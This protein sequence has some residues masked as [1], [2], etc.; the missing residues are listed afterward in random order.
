MKLSKIYSNKPNTF[1]PI[2]FVS[3]LNVILAEIRLPQNREKD[4][5][6]L[7]KTTLGGMIDFCLL[8][9]RNKKFFLFKHLDLFCEFIFFL[10]IELMDGSFVTVRR[11][12]DQASRIS[13]KTH[14]VGRQDFTKLSG[15]DWDHLDIS[16]DRAKTLLDGLLDFHTL[17]PWNYRKGLGYLIRS[18]DDFRDVFQLRKFASAHGDWKPFL[19]KILGFDEKLVSAHY[20]KEKEIDKKENTALTINAEMGSSVKDISKIEGFLLLK[21]RESEKKQTLLDSFDFREQDKEKTKSL[22]DDIDVRI[23]TLNSVRYSLN[24]NK[25]R[26]VSSLKEEKILFNPEEAQKLF[27]EAGIIFDGQIK[28]D[29]QQLIDFNKAITEERSAYLMEERVE[30]E[31]ELRHIN[32]ELNKLGKRRSESLSFLSDTDVFN[33]YKQISDELVT[34]KA[35]IVSLEH[36]RALSHRLQELRTEIRSL[37]EEKGKLQA[38]IENDVEKQNSEST[39]IFSSIRLFFSEIIE[40]VIDRKALLSVSPN[41]HGHLEFKAEILDESGN[42]TSADL[43]NT[44]RKLLCAAFDLSVLRVYLDQ[45]FPR[46][47]YHDGIFESLDHRKKENLLGII[48]KYTEYGIQNIITLIDSDLPATSEPQTSVF[49]ESE[50][51]LLLHDE[52]K[53]GRLFKMDSF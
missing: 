35:D 4:T 10:E 53:Q 21:K 50:I 32:A 28:K 8:S 22:V 45:D 14:R 11:S 29:Y 40:E 13:V 12:V 41:Q 26:V 18:Q 25:K 34:L 44:Y 43:G 7:G 49:D 38:E 48:R 3:T 31:K 30:I 16:F 23:A 47:V 46:F 52:G 5:H 17:K 42:T 20:E 36:Q 2:D 15:L 51:V 33:K 39:S 1:E 24:L 37:S 19:A 27:K 6:N 9:K